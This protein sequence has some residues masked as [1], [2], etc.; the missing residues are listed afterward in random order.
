M[1]VV[2]LGSGAAAKARKG[3]LVMKS[4]GLT[5]HTAGRHQRGEDFFRVLFDDIAETM[6]GFSTE[7]KKRHPA[8]FVDLTVWGGDSASASAS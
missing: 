1:Q 7:S 6:D 3:E 5:Q 4:P 2:D 8:L